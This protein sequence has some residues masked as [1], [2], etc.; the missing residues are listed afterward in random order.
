MPW[1]HPYTQLPAMS[2]Y[3][4]P[5]VLEHQGTLRKGPPVALVEPP[6]GLPP[7]SPERIDSGNH[8]MRRTEA[9]V[10]ETDWILGMN[11]Q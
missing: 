2:H 1:N 4:D 10:S 8:A 6:T 5:E 7:N 11:Q 3:A 9:K